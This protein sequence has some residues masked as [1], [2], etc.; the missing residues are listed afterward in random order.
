MLSDLGSPSNGSRILP[1]E[2]NDVYKSIYD[3]PKRGRP[4]Y[5]Y[6]G[7]RCF[8]PE[9]RFTGIMDFLTQSPEHM[10]ASYTKKKL[11]TFYKEDMAANRK[12]Y[13]DPLDNNQLPTDQSLLPQ[14][15]HVPRVASPLAMSRGATPVWNS[16]DGG[17]SRDG[18]PAWNTHQDTMGSRMGTAGSPGASRLN[19]AGS[20]LNT[21]GSTS[22]RVSKDGKDNGQSYAEM[23]RL[24]DMKGYEYA[25]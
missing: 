20:R 3:H 5:G 1:L 12:H 23:F 15:A 17:T 13:M 25:I 14:P 2:D 6:A 10:H 9:A 8:T 22:K 11:G 7:N 18:T 21:A 24:D 16:R 4:E 19:T